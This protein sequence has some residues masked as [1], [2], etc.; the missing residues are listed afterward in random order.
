MSKEGGD[1][2]DV[3]RVVIVALP[4]ETD[5]QGQIEAKIEAQSEARI[6][7]NAREVPEKSAGGGPGRD[8]PDDLS[9]KGLYLS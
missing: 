4:D 1:I 8:H 6:A 2:P 3:N 7:Q 9:N 5:T